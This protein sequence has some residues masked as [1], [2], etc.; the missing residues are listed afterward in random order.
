[1]LQN[2][3]THCTFCD[4]NNTPEEMVE[5]AISKGF[6]S[7]GFSSHALTEV[8]DD[9]E[10][11]DID[12]YIESIRGL[13]KRF[14][15]RIKLFL[16]IELDY[17]SKAPERLGDFDYSI[18]SAHYLILKNGEV[19]SYDHSPERTRKHIREDFSGNGLAFARSYF[20]TVARLEPKTAISFVGHFDLVTKFSQKH[21][22]FFDTD[23]PV[24]RSYALDALHTLSKKFDFF[25]INTGAIARGHKT[26]PY[27][28]P[29]IIDEMR[30]I[31][32]KILLTSDCH[33]KEFLDCK[34]RE[35][36]KYVRSHGFSELYFLTDDGFIGE[37]I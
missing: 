8:K 18:S 31:G 35:A 26:M 17:Y 37:K 13:K 28:A 12:G 11:R 24:Y 30:N 5:A 14:S 6:D 33:R 32:V 9:C 34:F 23:S 20:D 2:L 36:R 21:P 4:G 29:F 16:G 10:M 7:L 1:M 3:H 27:P 15:E 19:V 22:D 25:E